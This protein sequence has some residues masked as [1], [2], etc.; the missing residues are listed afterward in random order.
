MDE[1]NL[2]KF[3]KYFAV[4]NQKYVYFKVV[5]NFLATK[6][7]KNIKVCLKIL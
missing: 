6:I 5:F 7:V 4:N 3:S 1:N 2:S